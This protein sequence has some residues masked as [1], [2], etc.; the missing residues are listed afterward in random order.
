MKMAFPS[1]YVFS[2]FFHVCTMGLLVAWLNQIPDELFDKEELGNNY[3]IEKASSCSG[4]DSFEEEGNLVAC[5]NMAV[6]DN[7][8]ASESFDIPEVAVE[9]TRS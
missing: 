9:D 7:S 4:S 2:S 6:K 5:S 8:K 3:G 1:N